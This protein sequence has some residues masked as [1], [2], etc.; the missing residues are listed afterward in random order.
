MIAISNIAWDVVMDE[1]VSEVLCTSGVSY[2][3]IAPSKYFSHPSEVSEDELLKVKEYWIQ[4]GIEPLGMQSLLFGTQDL[5]VFGNLAVQDK[6]LSHLSDICHIGSILGA[7]KLVFG[8]PKNRNRSH[9]SDQQAAKKAIDFFIRLGD[10]AKS[11]NVVVCLEPNPTCY[12]SNF[13]TNSLDTARIVEA[14]DH[15]N[16]RMQLDIGAMCINAERAS[17]TIRRVAHLIHHIH[18][19]EPQLA[20]LDI[21]NPY[22]KEAAEAIQSF[23]PRMPVSIEMLTT[24]IATAIHEIESSIQVVKKIYQGN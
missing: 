10:V 12:Q 6:L 7:T 4:K 23:V 3:D 14:I 18:I 17:D 9:Y 11:K 22:H 2:I 8:S 24:N 1:E 15:D 16:I 19:S 20:P 5:N 21:T 13:M